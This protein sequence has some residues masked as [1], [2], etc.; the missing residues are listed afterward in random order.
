[1]HLS[2][3]TNRMDWIRSS[4]RTGR[5]EVSRVIYDNYGRQI[6]RV[7]FSYH[8]RPIN[9]SLPHLHQYEYG[10]AFDPIKGKE[11]VFNFWNK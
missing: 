6:Y 5:I 4:G 1:M 9:H 8:M 11:T 7:D 3:G 10:P 2:L